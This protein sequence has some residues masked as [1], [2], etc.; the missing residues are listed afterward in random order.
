MASK[1]IVA[2]CLK[3]GNSGLNS[4]ESFPRQR[5][6][7]I[8]SVTR[9]RLGEPLSAKMKPRLRRGKVVFA[10]KDKTQLFDKVFSLQSKKNSLKEMS[11]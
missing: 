4:E 5:N 7:T 8:A 11:V 9:Q 1:C 10:T 2:E 3:A 6:E